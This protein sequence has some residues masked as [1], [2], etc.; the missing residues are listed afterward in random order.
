MTYVTRKKKT[1]KKGPLASAS[2]HARQPTQYKQI[3]K[4]IEHILNKA[5]TTK[6]CVLAYYMNKYMYSE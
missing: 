3:P 4:C 1:N 6:K 2:A 5:R